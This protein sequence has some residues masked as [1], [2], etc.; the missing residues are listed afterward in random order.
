MFFQT[1]LHPCRV[2]KEFVCSGIEGFLVFR[3]QAAP[4]I[5]IAAIHEVRKK[6]EKWSGSGAIRELQCTAENKKAGRYCNAGY[7]ER[8]ARASLNTRSLPLGDHAPFEEKKLRHRTPQVARL[9]FSKNRHYYT[10]K[11]SRNAVKCHFFLR[12]K[13]YIRNM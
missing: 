4:I 5:L 8:V 2:N 3:T 6:S 11:G 1:V 7:C 9:I 12:H 10:E 13:M